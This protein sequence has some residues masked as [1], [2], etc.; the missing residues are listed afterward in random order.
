MLKMLSFATGLGLL[1]SF[2][3]SANLMT[4]NEFSCYYFAGGIITASQALQ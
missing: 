3:E 1:G 4:V 2:G